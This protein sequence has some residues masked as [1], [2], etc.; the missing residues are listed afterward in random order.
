MKRLTK[1]W[2]GVS[3]SSNTLLIC[4][5]QIHQKMTKGNTRA[6]SFFFF[7]TFLLKKPSQAKRWFL[8]ESK[9]T[10]DTPT[11]LMVRSQRILSTS[12]WSSKWDVDYESSLHMK[13]LLTKVNPFF[14]RLSQVKI[15]PY[16]A[17]QTKKETLM[18]A[19]DLQMTL[20]KLP[21]L[22]VSNEEE[23]HPSR[24]FK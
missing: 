20:W 7:L 24:S 6:T 23:P 12:Q 14:C 5:L 3:I 19:K 21:S 16:E 8:T 11:Q 4:S 9:A 1:R 15:F 10:Q 22:R 17:C 18:G 13:H 2:I